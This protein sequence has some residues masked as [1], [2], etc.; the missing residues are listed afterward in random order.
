MPLPVLRS[1]DS[2]HPPS[3]VPHETPD[4]GADSREQTDDRDEVQGVHLLRELR[5]GRAVLGDLQAGLMVFEQAR[6]RL[7]PALVRLDVRGEAATIPSNP[8][9]LARLLSILMDRARSSSAQ[10]R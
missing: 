1:C 7:D 6:Q 4:Q 3:L 8:S 9:S 5:D 2:P 10:A